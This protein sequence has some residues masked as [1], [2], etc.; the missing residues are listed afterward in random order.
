MNPEPAPVKNAIQFNRQTQPIRGLKTIVI[1]PLVDTMLLLSFFFILT[2]PLSVRSVIDVKLPKT[3]TS[4][5][6]KNENCIIKITNENIVYFNNKVMN[7]AELRSELS[8]EIYRA[9]PIII[10]A[11]RRA[12]VGRIVDIW[13]L[14][15]SL[16]IEQVNIATN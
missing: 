8:Q 7:I 9:R 10:Q 1:I 15:R 13:N 14:C 16:R 3:I 12:S 4:D 11:D 6:I 5:I 2:S